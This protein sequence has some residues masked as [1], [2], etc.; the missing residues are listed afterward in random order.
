[1]EFVVASDELK[2]KLEIAR[3]FTGKSTMDITQS[4]KLYIPEKHDVLVIE[5]SDFNKACRIRVK[6]VDIKSRGEAV[7][8]GERLQ[9]IISSFGGVDLY[10]RATNQLMI[11]SQSGE[12]FKLALQNPLEFPS[13]PGIPSSEKTFTIEAKDLVDICEKLEFATETSSAKKGISKP[14]AELLYF[15]NQ[16][17]FATDAF[18]LAAIELPDFSVEGM[19]LP[20]TALPLL[21][22]LDGKVHITPEGTNTYLQSGDFFY[23]LRAPDTKAPAAEQVIRS[24][25]NPKAIYEFQNETLNQLR[26]NLK[27]LAIIDQ[28]VSFIFK[29]NKI[30]MGSFSSVGEHICEVNVLAKEFLEESAAAYNVSFLLGALKKMTAPMLASF[31]KRSPVKITEGNYVCL[32]QATTQHHIEKLERYDEQGGVI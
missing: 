23:F 1:M 4:I 17:V 25:N 5:A 32:V 20:I 6:N 14:F 10:F 27:R 11:K 24:F 13:I 7:V 2:T 31:G 18:K 19:D 16:I 28:N 21:R 9:R 12:L 22:L 3:R 26:T 8:D 15:R 29:R 30:L